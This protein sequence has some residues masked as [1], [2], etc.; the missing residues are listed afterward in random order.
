MVIS[1][2]FCPILRE[3]FT[4]THIF[5][6]EKNTP[7][8]K[9]KYKMKILLIIIK[10]LTSPSKVSLT[11]TELSFTQFTTTRRRRVTKSFYFTFETD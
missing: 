9:C 8:N 10:I 4:D 2:C 6:H 1:D 7:I 11:G 3:K 5:S